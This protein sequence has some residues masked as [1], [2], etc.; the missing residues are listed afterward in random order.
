MA[1]TGGSRRGSG[2]HYFVIPELGRAAPYGIYDIAGIKGWVSVGVDHDT[3]AFA[4][5]AIRSWWR[6]MGR[7]RYPDAKS[8]LITADGG[9]SNGWYVRLWKLELQK[10][11]DDLGVPITV[12]HL[13]PSTSKWNGSEHRLFAFITGNWRGKP[14]VSHA[15]IVQ[16]IA[17]TKTKAGL[18]VRCGLGS[19][20]LTQPAS[21]SPTMILP[22]SKNRPPRFP[23]GEWSYTFYPTSQNS[24]ATAAHGS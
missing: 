5:N 6:S 8:L 13:P 4:V 14:L 15:V 23:H 11:A 22:P 18:E 10:L 17:A 16:L 1:A 20:T 2:V 21:K 19:P 24:V 9:G 12:C 3:A 7:E